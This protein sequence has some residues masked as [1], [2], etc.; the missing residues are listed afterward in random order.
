[1]MMQEV[2]EYFNYNK[3]VEEEQKASS[4]PEEE[5]KKDEKAAKKKKQ[6]QP[7]GLQF[8]KGTRAFFDYLLS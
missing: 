6:N 3:K 7:T 1:M 8:G 2:T 4:K 5:E